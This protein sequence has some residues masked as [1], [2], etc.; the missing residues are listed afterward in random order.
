MGLQRGIVHNPLSLRLA[1]A[2]H[3][4]EVLLV[5]ETE[6]EFKASRNGYPGRAVEGKNMNQLVLGRMKVRML[7]TLQRVR[8]IGFAWK[9]R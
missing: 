6:A 5:L 2:E 9:S 4:P 8:W 1:E 7:L 3:C